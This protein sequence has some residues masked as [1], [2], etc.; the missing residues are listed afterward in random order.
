MGRK[1]SNQPNK[2]V[3]RYR[4]L[5]QLGFSGEIRTVESLPQD[6]NMFVHFQLTL[7]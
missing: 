4:V 7:A 1:E 3:P 2:K 5:T 6:L